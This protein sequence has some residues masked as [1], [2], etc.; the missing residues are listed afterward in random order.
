MSRVGGLEEKKILDFI[1]EELMHDES[2]KCDYEASDVLKWCRKALVLSR[3]GSDG[4]YKPFYEK[5]IKR[6]DM[7]ILELENQL[8]E[9]LSRKETTELVD[10]SSKLVEEAVSGERKRILDGIGERFD[11]VKNYKDKPHFIALVL[12]E[13][14]RVKS[15]VLGEKF[16]KR[17]GVE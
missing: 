8:K 5:E 17:V 12:T 3:S 16:K 14:L 1:E 15:L 10:V 9:V 6:R 4:F 11:E 13:L 7:H 2:G